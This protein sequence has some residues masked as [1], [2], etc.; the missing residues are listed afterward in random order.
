MAQDE[1][2]KRAGRGVEESVDVLELSRR[3]SRLGRRVQIGYVAAMM[4]GLPV[5]VSAFAESS[6]H[7]TA[8]P[9]SSAAQARGMVSG[10]PFRD[11]RNLNAT[12]P[13]HLKLR[14]IA[15]ATRFDLGG[16]EIWG[17]S[18]DG[19]YIGPTMHVQP[20]ERVA[21]TLVNKLPTAT[22]L[23]FHGMHVSPSGS[24]DNPY[25][26]VP[27]GR[28]FV[29]HL[30]IP[31]DQPQGT[32]W[33]HDHDMCMGDEMMAMPGMPSTSPRSS[34]CADIESQI[35][36]GLSGSIIVG[37]DRSLL[38]PALRDIT[39]HTL[40]FKDL[41]VNKAGR[42]LQNAGNVSID[43]DNPTV[44]LVNGELR[45]V[46]T[47][48][49]GQTELWRLSNEGADI[50]YK[51]RLDGYRFTVIGQDGYPSAHVTTAGTL[52]LPPAKR[53]D[54]L[55]TASAH[56]SQTW[57]RTLALNTG[58]SG[59]S[60]PDA[61]LV[62]LRVAGAP[63]SPLAKPTGA[64]ATAQ[65]TLSDAHIARY[66]VLKPSESPDGSVMYINGKTFNMNKSIFSAPAVLGTVE[67][68]TVY[69]ESSEIH[70][71]H[72][73][74]DHFQVM[75]INGVPQRY[76][77]EQDII[78]VPYKKKGRERDPGPGA[79][80]SAADTFRLGCPNKATLIGRATDSTRTW[81][82]PQQ[83]AAAN[84]GS[85]PATG[86]RSSHPRGCRA[87]VA[88]ATGV[89]LAVALAA[90]GSSSPSSSKV[91]VKRACQQVAAVLADGPD[92][93]VD[94][95]GYAEAQVLPLRQIRTPQKPL[96]Q[97]I[98]ELASAYHAF[99]SANG[100][101]ATKTAVTAASRQIDAVCPE[102]AQ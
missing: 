67:Q 37:D 68:W 76:T 65:P 23:H 38:P 102:A 28:S 46:L 53:Y 85:D 84:M 96:Q 2:S 99:S 59:D 73:H 57:L 41:Q 64:V 69:N 56:P 63:M 71:F 30:N 43:S 5:A 21:L 47:M 4:V 52:L 34:S 39:A 100:S 40:V 74:T 13:R 58:P 66:R 61:P 10:L 29:Y 26:S 17:D 54:V 88:A 42:I 18:Y 50:F 78:P 7:V 51:L 91:A 94:P 93:G 79:G 35:F 101:R 24:S 20:G 6:G 1:A 27:P 49:P 82:R 15:A 32:F 45:P 98:D 97:K 11:P 8:A 86:H 25:I 95:V 83:E 81:P 80:G 77:G 36:A 12:T 87:A 72:I 19:S 55:V 14:L 44:R 22:N 33:Y 70:P 3:R 89:F 62:K 9:P 75:S 16:K 48:R 60:Y 92:P 31:R 90:C